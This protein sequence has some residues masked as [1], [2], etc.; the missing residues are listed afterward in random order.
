MLTSDEHQDTLLQ[1][2]LED[3]GTPLDASAQGEIEEQDPWTQQLKELLKRE[4][5]NEAG[6]GWMHPWTRLVKERL[7]ESFK[8]DKVK[9]EGK[10]EGALSTDLTRPP[11]DKG[12]AEGVAEQERRPSSTN[13]DLVNTIAELRNMIASLEKA[14]NEPI[15]RPNPADRETQEH[16]Q[17]DGPRE[18]PA[19]G[20]KCNGDMDHNRRRRA[21]N[22]A[23]MPFES[24]AVCCRCLRVCLPVGA[25]VRATRSSKGDKVKGEGE[26]KRSKP[27]GL[28]EDPVVDASSDEGPSSEETRKGKGGKC[29]KSKGKGKDGKL[30]KGKSTVLREQFCNNDGSGTRVVGELYENGT[31]VVLGASLERR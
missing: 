7:K 8:G 5:E 26:G 27:P 24:E 9:D 3:E 17:G 12:K 10:G 31:R 11:P 13:A 4:I 30:D 29:E 14:G 1:L 23:G 22:T 19:E 18:V 25:R 6:A 28:L 21:W 2:L 15:H 16:V 20:R